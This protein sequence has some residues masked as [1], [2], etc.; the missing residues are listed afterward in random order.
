MALCPP[1][2]CSKL[3]LVLIRQDL[4][5][6]LLSVH[7]TAATLAPAPPA[8]P[9]NNNTSSSRSSPS[10]PE[11]LIQ[12]VENG[13]NPDIYTREFVELVRRLNQL[14]RGKM[15]AF[16]GFRDVLARDMCAAMPELRDDVR[17]VLEATGGVAVDVK[18]GELVAAGGGER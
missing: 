11:P 3:T 15:H 6:T 16:G 13:R 5:T 4:S 7:N 12:Y 17:R 1:L 18:N 8:P 10:I 14:V 2:P 9:V